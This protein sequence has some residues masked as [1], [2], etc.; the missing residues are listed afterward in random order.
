MDQL[1]VDMFSGDIYKQCFKEIVPANREVG[2]REQE[3]LNNCISKF[4]ESYQIVANSFVKFV[5]DQPS[6]AFTPDS[7]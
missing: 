2:Q 3:E 4:H 7:D 5:Q 1:I 6:K